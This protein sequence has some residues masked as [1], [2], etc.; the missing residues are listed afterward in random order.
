VIRLWGGNVDFFKKKKEKK[1][2]GN[3]SVVTDLSK[4]LGGG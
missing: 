3:I 1:N 2:R 4:T